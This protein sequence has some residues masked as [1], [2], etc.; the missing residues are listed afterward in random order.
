MVVTTFTAVCII[1]EIKP[2]RASDPNEP[3]RKPERAWSK[4]RDHEDAARGRAGEALQ[5]GGRLRGRAAG[6]RA[7]DH[8]V[9]QGQWDWQYE[10]KLKLYEIVQF[11]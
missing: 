6:L 11:P 8:R 2:E 10:T 7:V 5:G 4:G 1:F 3:G 9:H